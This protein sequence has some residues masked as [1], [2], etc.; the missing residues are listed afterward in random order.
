MLFIFTITIYLFIETNADVGK[1]S[2]KPKWTISGEQLKTTL[3]ASIAERFESNSFN[4]NNSSWRILSYPNGNNEETEGSYMIF[5]Y[6]EEMSSE[7]KEIT[8]CLTIISPATNSRLT[9]VAVYNDSKGLGWYPGTLLLDEIKEMD[10]LTELE[11]V[12]EITVLKI[13]SV[14]DE[15]L[16]QHK[17]S[18]ST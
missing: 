4:L 1:F 5:A 15:I 8:I 12:L 3:N 17:F 2:Y 10:D 16:Y 6:L 11:W 14:D 7:W 18:Y 13:V 9:R